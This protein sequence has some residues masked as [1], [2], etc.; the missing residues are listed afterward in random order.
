MIRV[1]L[2]HGGQKVGNKN[3]SY[4]NQINYQILIK[5]QGQTVHKLQIATFGDIYSISPPI[6]IFCIYTNQIIFFL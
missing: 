2:W 3:N 6:Y 5:K 1:S 4:W